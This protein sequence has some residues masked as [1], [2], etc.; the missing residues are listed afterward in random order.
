MT[1]V[2]NSS[3]LSPDEGTQTLS[4]GQLAAAG[5]VI[6]PWPTDVCIECGKPELPKHDWHPPLCDLCAVLWYGPHA[7]DAEYTGP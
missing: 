4:E 2:L 5:G 6:P 3:K 1:R 7:E